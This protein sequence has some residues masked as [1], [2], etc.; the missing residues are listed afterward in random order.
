MNDN[1]SLRL[2]VQ[3][4]VVGLLTLLIQQAGS[5]LAAKKAETGMGLAQRIGYRL[6]KLWAGRNR[7][8]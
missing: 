5:R 8:R 3:V 6:G 1:D 7:S 2:M 4:V